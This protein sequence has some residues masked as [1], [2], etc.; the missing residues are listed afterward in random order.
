VNL[1][2][3]L[4]DLRRRGIQLRADGDR[5][6]CNAPTGV[7]TPQLRS[8]IQQR[9]SEILEFLRTAKAL[10]RQQRAIVP[11]QPHGNRTPVYAVAGHNGDVFAYRALARHLGD[12][13]PFFGLQPPGLDDHSEPLAR[14]EAL[15]GYFATQIREFQPDGP[16]IIAGYCAG[17][18]IA[19]ELARQLRRSGATISF[20]AL[21]ACPFPTFY[22]FGAQLTQR[23]KQLA[24]RAG[25]HAR[26]LATL[27]SEERRL[28]ISERLRT[29][30]ARR[31]AEYAAAS[32][33]ALAVR[34]KVGRAI[35][36]A[37]RR[38]TPG[39]FSGRVG[40]FLPNREWLRS[41]AA[42][43][44]WR[45]VAMRTEEYYGPDNCN[46]DLLLL[47]PDAPA[48]AKLFKQFRDGCDE[49]GSMNARSNRPQHAANAGCVTG[50]GVHT[51]NFPVGNLK[52]RFK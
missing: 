10:A 2:S 3:F 25:M 13:Q 37:V 38:Y 21:F 43:L 32:D 44:R 41:G 36:T 5:L 34:A 20:L 14:V 6:H 7:L 12:D 24:V 19:F 50:P 52:G 4:A 49:V 48:M 42:P 30:K 40:L 23:L 17:G 31:D 27:S 29:R 35:I 8:Q 33:P 15:A 51:G 16:Y 28:Y 26:A 47:E 9:K 18:G 11:L 39:S 1:Q 22:R 45:S 46:P